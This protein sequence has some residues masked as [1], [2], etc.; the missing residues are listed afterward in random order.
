MGVVVQFD[1]DSWTTRYPELAAVPE[2]LAELYFNEATLYCRNDG[3]GQVSSSD[4]QSMLLNM[5]TAHIAKINIPVNG[6]PSPDTVGRIS[7]ASEGSV[8]VALEMQYPPGTAQWFAQTK[9]GAAYWAAAAAYR[10]MQYFPGPQRNFEP[11]RNI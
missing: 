7:N 9:Y 3:S 6:Q 2:A 8:S 5:L 10:T 1:Y 11:F 4:T